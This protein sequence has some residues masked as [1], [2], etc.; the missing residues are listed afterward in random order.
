M[1]LY[2][3]LDRSREFS[4]RSNS[5]GLLMK[6]FENWVTNYRGQYLDDIL[7]VLPIESFGL[8]LKQMLGSKSIAEEDLSL[9]SYQIS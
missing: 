3:P 1:L 8:S 2:H 9:Q 7:P 4:S 6:L 5:I